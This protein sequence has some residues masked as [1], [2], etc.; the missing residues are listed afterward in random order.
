MTH[1]FKRFPVIRGKP[2]FFPMY[3]APAAGARYICLKPC[4]NFEKVRSGER[5]HSTNICMQILI[6]W[7]VR[8]E[9]AFRNPGKRKA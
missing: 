5:G 3:Y 1:H 4:P 6:A 2:H 9:F 7:L 8:S